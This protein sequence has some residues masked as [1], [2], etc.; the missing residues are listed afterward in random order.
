[1]TELRTEQTESDEDKQERLL[2]EPAFIWLGES[3]SE[4]LAMLRRSGVCGKIEYAQS[5]HMNP[6]VDMAVGRYCWHDDTDAR[7]FLFVLESYGNGKPKGS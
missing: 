1:M 7:R 6:F 2:T 5:L 4:I 3:H